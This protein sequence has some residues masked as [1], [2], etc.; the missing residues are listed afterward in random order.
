MLSLI[1]LVSTWFFLKDVHSHQFV[2]QITIHFD[3]YLDVFGTA[4]FLTRLPY[5]SN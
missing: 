4:D 3:K 5:L 2:T 1:E